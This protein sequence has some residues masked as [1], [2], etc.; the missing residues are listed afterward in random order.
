MKKL[1]IILGVLA[2]IA[3]VSFMYLVKSIPKHWE[4][5]DVLNMKIG[6]EVLHA[7]DIINK[8]LESGGGYKDVDILLENIYNKLE[9]FES[10]GDFQYLGKRNWEFSALTHDSWE[11]MNMYCTVNQDYHF[12]GWCASLPSECIIF[13]EA[14][15]V[16]NDYEKADYNVSSLE[17][18]IYTKLEMKV[19]EDYFLVFNG[20]NDWEFT[21]IDPSYEKTA[22]PYPRIDQDYEIISCYDPQI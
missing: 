4:E 12:E 8:H 11:T 13:N 21:I 1:L 6:N 5:E 20:E 22:D 10:E 3:V 14:Y 18:V 19:D 17:E 16:I 2:L 9:S 15:V 7:Y